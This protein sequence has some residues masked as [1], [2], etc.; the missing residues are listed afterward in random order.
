MHASS[1]AAQKQPSHMGHV[2]VRLP[3]GGISSARRNESRLHFC[4]KTACCRAFHGLPS[5]SDGDGD[6]RLSSARACEAIAREANGLPPPRPGVC[7]SVTGCNSL[8]S[9]PNE[10][11]G[12]TLKSSCQDASNAPRFVAFMPSLAST[13]MC[14][15]PSPSMPPGR[16]RR[17]YNHRPHHHGDGRAPS[18]TQPLPTTRQKGQGQ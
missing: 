11:L 8:K 18:G 13:R 5:P 6:T 3:L 17:G 14:R 15:P 9:P 16:E 7:N 12:M 10:T 2:L 4:G 1:L